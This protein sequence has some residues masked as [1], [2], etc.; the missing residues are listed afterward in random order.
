MPERDERGLPI[1]D[2]AI[3]RP[4]IDVG[5]DFSEVCRSAWNALLSAN[6]EQ[7]PRVL[8]HGGKLTTVVAAD[9]TAR[10]QPYDVDS[11][12][13]R[14]AECASFI[15]QVRGSAAHSYPPTQVVRTLLKFGTEPG[16]HG[17]PPS[18]SRVVTAPVYDA[19]G[20]L[21]SEPGLHP[22]GLYLEPA[23]EMAGFI[24]PPSNPDAD[25]MEVAH[26]LIGD[27]LHDFPFVTE[28]DRANAI[29]LMLL[30][31]VRDMADGP[32]PLHYIGAPTPGTGKS[33][34]ARVL[35]IP[36]LGVVPDIAGPS[37]DEEWRKAITTY[38]MQ[39][40]SALFFDDA[41]DLSSRQL[42]QALTSAVWQDRVLGASV[43]A[44]LPVRC[45]WVATGNNLRVDAAIARRIVPVRLDSNVERPWYR[46]EWRHPGIEEFAKRRRQ[47]LVTAALTVVNS[48]VWAQRH[49][50]G[51]P[52]GGATISYP[53]YER[54]VGGLL[55][56]AGY[57]GF[58][59]NHSDFS[60]V[61]DDD[62]LA[63][64]LRAWHDLDLGPM[65]AR[66]LE[67]L[68]APIGALRHAA[69]D[70]IRSMRED[71]LAS[72]LPYWLR[73][74]RDRVA[75]GLKLVVQ[76]QSGTRRTWSVVEVGR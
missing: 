67:S 12:A 49:G 59:E 17:R 52:V 65:S 50:E 45:V 47:H 51:A 36:A 43:Q 10:L 3:V 38:L 66:D 69:P 72:R 63:S 53:G 11:L 18:I 31:F 21:V 29:G 76:N 60:E 57:P 8:L 26:H 46:R 54:V 33:T 16:V 23:P 64:F 70:S 75:D 22:S 39:S 19:D 27:L 24:P 74:R 37:E 25:D 32:T 4:M 68:V 61:E 62:G 35:L 34:L 44:Q 1:V 9:G 13:F 71:Q 58:L 15:R 40:P 48:W 55:A 2:G 28:S 20:N 42:A 30:P 6:D 14:L 56:H 73:T 5:D 41:G 7:R